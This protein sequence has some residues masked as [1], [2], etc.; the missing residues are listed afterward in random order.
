MLFLSWLLPRLHTT[1]NADLKAL[2]KITKLHISCARIWNKTWFHS[3]CFKMFLCLKN[4]ASWD[5][6]YPVTKSPPQN[7]NVNVAVDK[8]RFTNHGRKSSVKK[9]R[10]LG[11][12][13]CS[14]LHCVS[15]LKHEVTL[16]L[17]SSSWVMALSHLAIRPPHSPTQVIKQSL[18]AHP[19][20]PIHVLKSVSILVLTQRSLSRNFPPSICLPSC[21]PPPPHW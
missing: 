6:N 14:D 9:C 8:H 20:N 16:N 13:E 1:G 18:A 19:Q 4:V 11:W 12:S 17:C 7:A 15:H 21:L 2:L 5:S 10:Y 3:S